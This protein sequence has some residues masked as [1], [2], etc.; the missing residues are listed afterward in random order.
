MGG[1]LDFISSIVPI[2]G[3]SVIDTILFAVIGTVAFVGAW[4]ITGSLAELIGFDPNGMSLIHWIV[5]VAIWLGLLFIVSL[6]VSVIRWFFSFEWWVY[7]IIGVSLALIA[8]GVIALRIVLEKKKKDKNK[9]E[10]QD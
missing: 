4:I 10:D 1:I 7:I 3:N 5:R 6:I 8:C 2:T 9:T